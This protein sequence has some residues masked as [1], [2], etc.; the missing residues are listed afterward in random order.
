M[1][2]I[3][4]GAGAIGGTIAARVFQHGHDVVLMARGAHAAA[5]RTHGLRFE[6]PD[7]AV[8]LPIPMLDSVD[9]LDSR[10]DDVVLLAVKSQDTSGALHALS[11]LDRPD[12]PIVCAQNG[13]AN[14]PLALRFF[15]NVYG[16]V[17]MS[18]TAHLEPGLVQ[19]YSTPVTGILD[20]GRYPAGLDGTS[21]GLCGMFA[22]STYASAQR[23]D[24]VAWK[25][26][27]LLANLTNAIEALCGTAE[28]RKG[29]VARLAVEEGRR[30]LA[31]A[32][33]AVSEEDPDAGRGGLLT[34]KPIGSAQRP[35]GSM[36]QSLR[37]H[38]ELTE[39]DYLN[40]EV[41]RLG[42]ELAIPTPVNELLQ[43][44]VTQVARDGHA[45]GRISAEQLLIWARQG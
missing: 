21:A 12:L 14:E 32:G 16:V 35:G 6:S 10:P 7:E 26:G 33:I 41:V 40:G 8:C 36:L 18:P 37:R 44:L 23:A 25:H 3:V 38:S 39:V 22:A 30:C 13:V 31:A 4:F 27:K 42:R 29:Q 24:I 1:R 28:S 15:R 17:V 45:P 19:A 5:I 11:W 20:V 43:R 2:L 9:A 34:P